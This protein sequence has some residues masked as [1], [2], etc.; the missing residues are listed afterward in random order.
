M[1]IIARRQ[2]NKHLSPSS[3]LCRF[4][5]R[6]QA[7][8]YIKWFEWKFHEKSE[9]CLGWSS[10]N[11]Q[12]VPTTKREHQWRRDANSRNWK[13]KCNH[14]KSIEYDILFS[15]KIG[16]QILFVLEL[17]HLFYRNLIKWKKRNIRIVILGQFSF[18]YKFFD[19]Y[20][21]F[22]GYIIQKNIFLKILWFLRKRIYI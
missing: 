4:K 6:E 15:F 19:K 18:N 16:S 22:Y 20:N 9:K 11:E 21:T 8:F 3:P 2:E 13:S 10:D 7:W 5:K 1:G 12:T 17:I 14:I